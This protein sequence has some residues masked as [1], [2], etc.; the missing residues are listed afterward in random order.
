MIAAAASTAYSAG[1]RCLPGLSAVAFGAARAAF[2]FFKRHY[3]VIQGSAGL[4]LV[5]M[6]VLVL[7]GEL[8]RLNIPCKQ[9]L[10]RYGLNFFT[11]V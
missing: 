10:D 9:L 2:A 11:S 6:G 4:V 8:F 5:A 1:S 7:T 3:L